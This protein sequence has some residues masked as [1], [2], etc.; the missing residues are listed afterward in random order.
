MGMTG[1]QVT[2]GGGDGSTARS[3]GLVAH[4]MAEHP[5]RRA[6]SEELHARPYE[7][8]IAPLRASHLAM[9]STE[10]DAAADRAHVAALCRRCGAPPPDAEARH[11]SVELGP[12]RLKWERHTEFST[13]SFFRPADFDDPF[14]APAIELVP[15][16]WLAAL[17]GQRL[18]AVHVALEP[19]HGRARSVEDLYRL[20]GTD[21]IAGSGMSGG[22]AE[23]Y[24]DFRLHEDGFGRILVRDISLKPRQAGR[25]I[26]RLLEI[27]TYRMM[28]LLAFPQAREVGPKVSAI[29]RE[30]AG[31]A[32][33]MGEIRGIGDEQHLLEH[34]TALSTRVEQLSASTSYRFGAS[35]A[36]YALV[37]RRIEELRESRI[38]GLQTV[39]EF[40]DRRLAPAMRTC[41][42]AAARL[43]AS[44]GRVS[45]SASLLLTRVDLDLEGQ[46]QE[47]LQSM[48]RRAKL[49][50]RLQQAVEGL[51]VTAISYYL[52]SLVG[53]VAK[54]V[55]RVG[56]PADP[57]IVQGLAI[58]PV[59]VL[60]GL[61]IRHVRRTI[62]K[63]EARGS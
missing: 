29:D 15:K 45:R 32:N 9:V 60:V 33:T 44:A 46:N 25:L 21:N 63:V 3:G 57:A 48:N 55:E 42:S 39:R 52:V 34:L 58:V 35:R 4:H 11:L 22:A 36:Y 38:E 62:R 19:P 16:D 51:S 8:L 6:L 37:D 14:P 43:D 18:V 53:Y 12:Y 61:G 20:F 23:A 50:L 2:S 7:A 41:E 40:L 59:V 47:L 1:T 17:P 13:Y 5:W 31:I 10:E 26:Q 54:A 56:V 49:Q 27:E 30:L 28:A 24:T